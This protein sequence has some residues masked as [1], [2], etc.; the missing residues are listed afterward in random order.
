MSKRAQF[1]IKHLLISIIISIMIVAWVLLIWYPEPLGIAVGVSQIFYM[2]VAIDV[3]LGPI[4]G[5]IVYNE[6]KKS[7]KL[8]LSIIII[9]QV[10]ALVYG[11]FNLEKGR[12][13]WIAYNVDRFELIRKNEIYLK[14]IEKANDKYKETSFLKPQYVAV[15]FALDNKERNNNMFDEV[16]AGISIAQRPERYVNIDQVK[17][18]IKSRSQNLSVLNE[19]NSR[20]QVSKILNQYPLADSWLP[21]KASALDMVVLMNKEKAEVVKIVDLRPWN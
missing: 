15:K 1:F 9:F 18:Q 10:I 16:I 6:N 5:F 7:L 4:L 2:M 13:V 17:N 19:F 12:P 21:L 3:I 8:D 11:V 20:T 14:D